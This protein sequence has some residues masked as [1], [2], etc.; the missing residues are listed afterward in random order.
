MITLPWSLALTL[1]LPFILW[2]HWP[3]GIIEITFPPQ[4]PSLHHTYKV[5]MPHRVTYAQVLGIPCGHLWEP[6]CCLQYLPTC[7][8]FEE[9]I[10]LKHFKFFISV[11]SSFWAF[12]HL[13]PSVFLPQEPW[14]INRMGSLAFWW[15]GLSHSVIVFSVSRHWRD[16]GEMHVSPDIWQC[17]MRQDCSPFQTAPLTA[18]SSSQGGSWLEYRKTL[19]LGIQGSLWSKCMLHPQQHG[20]APITASSSP[21][22]NTPSLSTFHSLCTHTAPSNAPGL[23]CWVGTD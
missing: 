13:Y 19:C 9:E 15:T 14:A 8:F 18:M 5:P 21:A 2:L 3:T 1:H 17:Q 11:R 16:V 23:L 20:P 7:S 10:M 4:D 12:A 22:Q 6:L